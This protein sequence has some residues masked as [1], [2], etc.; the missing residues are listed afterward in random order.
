M[1]K[2]GYIMLYHHPPTQSHA[3]AMMKLCSLLS[4]SSDDHDGGGFG[5]RA[6]LYQCLAH[7]VGGR[8]SEYRDP[9]PRPATLTLP[10]F[11]RTAGTRVI[12]RGRAKNR[13]AC[14]DDQKKVVFRLE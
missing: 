11:L 10:V 3:Y 13:A 9:S 12:E 2:S 8:S 14:K 6:L 5:R 1:L 7:S 4:T